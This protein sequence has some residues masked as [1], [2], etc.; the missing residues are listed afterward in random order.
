MLNVFSARCFVSRRGCVWM[1]FECCCTAVRENVG[2]QHAVRV[3][4]RHGLFLP[5]LSSKLL[6]K[7]KKNQTCTFQKGK[8]HCGCK[9]S[10]EAA[11]HF[12]QHMKGQRSTKT[13]LGR[14]KALKSSV[15]IMWGLVEFS[16]T[17]QEI[18]LSQNFRS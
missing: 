6:F 7:K 12:T 13:L 3:T 9:N 5:A 8:G 17:F 14:F 2:W 16:S 1:C 18:K 11:C 10:V 4:N 15:K